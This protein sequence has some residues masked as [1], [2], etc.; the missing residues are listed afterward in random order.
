MRFT[1]ARMWMM[2]CRGARRGTVKPKPLR[3]VVV[4]RSRRGLTIISEKRPTASSST[5]PPNGRALRDDPEGA[6]L[7]PALRQFLDGLAEIIARDLHR[8]GWIARGLEGESLAMVEQD[9]C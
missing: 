6:N 9:E 2:A 4:R 5:F 1:S 3:L 8:K 7:P